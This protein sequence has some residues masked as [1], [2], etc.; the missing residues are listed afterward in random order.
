MRQCRNTWTRCDQISDTAHPECCV[1]S[2]IKGAF[3][4]YVCVCYSSVHLITFNTYHTA[5]VIRRHVQNVAT[6]KMF[7]NVKHFGIR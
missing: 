3:S 5:G 7:K 2:P 1:A 6:R 4:C